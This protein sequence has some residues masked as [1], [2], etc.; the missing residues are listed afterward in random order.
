MKEN[1]IWIFCE[2][3]DGRL[4]VTSTELLTKAQDLKQK[5]REP[6]SV[7]AVVLDEKAQ[8]YAEEAFSFGAECF[9]CAENPSLGRYNPRIFAR[10]LSNLSETY[11][12]SIFLFPASDVGHE[13]APRLMCRLQ[14]GLTADAVN[15]DIDDSGQFYQTTPA[16]GG[17][18]LAN[19]IIPEKRPQMVTVRE[20][21]F[22][23]AQP[24]AGR[25]GEL[26]CATLSLP[27]DDSY[28]LLNLQRDAQS[29]IDISTV[30]VLVSCGR[31]VKQEDLPMM[32]ELAAL[33]GGVVACSR[34]L[35]DCGWFPHERQIGQ[36]GSTVSPELIM[37]V[38]VSG[39]V[40][41]VSG[42]AESKRIISINHAA[43]A[44]IFSISHDGVVAE[45]QD[46]IPALIQEI[47]KRKVGK[48]QN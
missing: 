20:H 46:L 22:Q 11:R 16:F 28:V 3:E 9:L 15:I 10:A 4:S 43:T 24:V 38:A 12:P 7:V 23:A 5:M 33:L 47:R 17:K 27:E 18:V 8:S 1:S 34:P 14:T 13:L 29:Q 45:Y 44:P 25:S 36:S 31:G 26:I 39:S 48:T 40:P 2:P 21:A 42:M 35:C 37:N 6:A 41:Y 32:E 19:I 30:P